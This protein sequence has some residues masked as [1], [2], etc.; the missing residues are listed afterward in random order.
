M[1]HTMADPVEILV[2]LTQLAELTG[3]HRSTLVRMEQR[4]VIPPGDYDPRYGG[5]VYDQKAV[6]AVF[7]ALKKYEDEKAE[8]I[9]P[10]GARRQPREGTKIASPADIQ[11]LYGRTPAPKEDAADV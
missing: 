2:T 1:E 3:Y 8:K 7:E 4:L 11:R 5:R 10:M 9:G 6:K